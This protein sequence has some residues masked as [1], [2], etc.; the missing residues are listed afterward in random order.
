MLGKMPVQTVKQ[1][2]FNADIQLFGMGACS[3]FGNDA[4]KGTVEVVLSENHG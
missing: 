4:A 2:L 3:D 1:R